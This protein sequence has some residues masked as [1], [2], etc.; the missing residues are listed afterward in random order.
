MIT[1]KHDSKANQIKN[2]HKAMEL[3]VKVGDGIDLKLSNS[4]FNALK[5]HSVQ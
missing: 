2:A 3:D 5:N 4:V 1:T